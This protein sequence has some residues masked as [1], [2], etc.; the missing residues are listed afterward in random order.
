[1]LKQ[2]NEM[3]VDLRNAG[4]QAEKSHGKH[5]QR[6]CGTG[7]ADHHFVSTAGSG[8]RSPCQDGVLA[9]LP[10]GDLPHSYGFT[11]TFDA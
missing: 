9:A 8:L 6:S 7:S 4:K 3:S 2:A 1:M 10:L 5:N 11:L